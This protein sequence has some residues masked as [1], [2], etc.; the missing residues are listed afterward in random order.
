[1]L[2][3]GKHIG[4]A[5]CY[6]PLDC[7]SRFMVPRWWVVNTRPTSF[8]S[9]F[10][11]CHA[12]R[13]QFALATSASS[14]AVCGDQWIRHVS[15][16]PRMRWLRERSPLEASMLACV[17]ERCLLG[18]V[19]NPQEDP[20]SS[21]ATVKSSIPQTMLRA[22]H[23]REPPHDMQATRHIPTLTSDSTERNRNMMRT[24]EPMS[25]KVKARQC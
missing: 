2:G 24:I 22:R 3:I 5:L 6:R 17:R 16:M 15:R 12:R 8:V 1:M 10:G 9:A 18:R 21:D 4:L 11:V 20:A 7:L 19:P 25:S 14:R 13:V 23:S